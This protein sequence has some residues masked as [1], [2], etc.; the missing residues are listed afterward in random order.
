MLRWHHTNFTTG[1]FP[2]RSQLYPLREDFQGS[3]S[4]L[5]A[6][7]ETSGPALSPGGVI[8]TWGHTLLSR[9]VLGFHTQVPMLEQPVLLHSEPFFESLG[10][11]LQ[12]LSLPGSIWM[13]L[14]DWWP[15]QTSLRTLGFP[16]P[17]MLRMKP[18]HFL[19]SFLLSRMYSLAS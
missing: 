8:R 3:W 16:D 2:P 5:L 12:N 13:C 11:V 1:S 14:F 10:T 9:H 19:V 17:V 6:G 4:P 18:V 15:G 7:S